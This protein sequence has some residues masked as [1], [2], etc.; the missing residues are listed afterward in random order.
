M[1]S[2]LNSLTCSGVNSI[3]RMLV[4]LTL[5]LA[6][7]GLLVTT[8]ILYL[9]LACL[10]TFPFLL[11]SFLPLVSIKWIIKMGRNDTQGMALL[12]RKT[13]GNGVGPVAELSGY[14]QY[15][16][17]RFLGYVRLVI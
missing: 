14:T 17:A 4:F 10:S 13:A 6:L 16:L 11:R 3:R 1:L 15:L 8:A 9:A 5:A 2:A 7:G 12:C